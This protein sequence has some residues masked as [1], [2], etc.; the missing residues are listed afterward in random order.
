MRGDSLDSRLQAASWGDDYQLL[1]SAPPMPRCRLLQPR[2]DMCVEGSGWR[3]LKP[4]R[5]YRC[6]PRSVINII[7]A[8][9]R[10]LRL[11]RVA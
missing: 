11:L 6:R 9:G 7:D 3:C 2:S 8:F 1:F 4:M 10:F 5:R